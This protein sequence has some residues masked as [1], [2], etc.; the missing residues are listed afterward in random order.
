M[1]RPPPGPACDARPAVRWVGIVN[2]T[3]DSFSDGGTAVDAPAASRRAAELVAAGAEG[4]DVGAEST[5][6]GFS[7]VPWR[8][9][10]RRLAATLPAICAA[11]GGRAWVSVD[12][13][14][15]GVAAA[16][17]RMGAD[18][19]NDVGGAASRGMKAF[20]ANFRG[21]YVLAHGMAHVLAADDAHP[22]QSVVR[23]LSRAMGRLEDLGVP[24]ENIAVDPG[25]GFG[26]TRE[27]DAA[28]L[29]ALDAI[30]AI[31]R[32]VWLG[33]SRKRIVRRFQ[34]PGE[35]LDAAS[36]RLA[37]AAVERLGTS[38]PPVLLRMHRPFPGTGG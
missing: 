30:C 18:V 28:L 14:K 17:V 24:R 13:R 20:L 36:W 3:P 32:D 27:Q 1:S 31:G 23:W 37:L 19:V 25:I 11:V 35:D 8:E 4:V 16:A 33:L 2:V 6:P 34:R 26:T 7:P 12:T 9:E 5:R 38:R 21:R 29:D 22:A 15:G 10:V